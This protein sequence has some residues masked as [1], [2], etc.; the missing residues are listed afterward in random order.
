MMKYLLLG[1]FNLLFWGQMN[2]CLN[3]YYSV[4]KNGDLHPLGDF[5][6]AFNTNFNNPLLERRLKKTALKI[7]KT[8]DFRL[9]SDYAV[10]LLKA[11]KGAEAVAIFE[12]LNIDYPNQYEILSNLGTAYEVIGQDEKALLFIKKAF[13]LNADSHFGSEWIHIKVLETKLLLKQDPDY[14]L[15]TSV[16]KLTEIQKQDT[17][18]RNQILL[19]VRERFPFIKGPNAIMASLLIDLADCCANTNSIEVAK[20]FYTIAKNYYG[21]DELLIGKKIT[22]MVRLRQQYHNVQPKRLV[23]DG[24]NIKISGISYNKM[25]DDNNP[26]NYSINWKELEYQPNE[27]LSWIK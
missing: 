1:C 22:E 15:K 18:I 20:A 2:A 27:V 9:V 21:A 25:L 16:L 23:G 8:K 3:Y 12:Q 14:L 4:D 5:R 6:R 11:G 13:A 26:N 17:L 7:K 19:Q 10:F 24:D